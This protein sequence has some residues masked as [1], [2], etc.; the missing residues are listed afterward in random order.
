MKFRELVEYIKSAR[1]TAD[2]ATALSGKELYPVWEADVAVKVGDRY[3]YGDKLYKCR[4]AHTTE[5]IRT[6][7]IIPA[8]WDV[9]DVNHAGTLEDPIPYDPNMEVFN[10][11]Y[12]IYDNVVY[13]CIRDSGQPLYTTPDTL[14]NN[15]FELV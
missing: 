14:L 7:D 2:D 15:Y 9:I 3:R 8:L 10:G 5:A 6:P 1:L 13:L 11:K 12:Y 4:Q